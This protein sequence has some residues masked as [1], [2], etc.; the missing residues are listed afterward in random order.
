MQDSILSHITTMKS[1][2][3]E[4]TERS[5]QINSQCSP[6]SSS[7][8]AHLRFPATLGLGDA[9]PALGTGEVTEGRNG[10][11]A[12][13]WTGTGAASTGAGWYCLVAGNESIFFSSMAYTPVSTPSLPQYISICA[14]TIPFRTNAS[15]KPHRT[16]LSPSSSA[17]VVNRRAAHPRICANTAIAERL[18]VDFARA[19]EAICGILEKS[20]MGRVRSWRSGRKVCGTTTKKTVDRATMREARSAPWVFFADRARSPPLP[21]AEGRWYTMSTVTMTFWMARKRFSPSI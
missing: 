17:L 4:N 6:Q 18:P 15:P 11:D 19:F 16:Y 20:E 9:D 13:A 21:E 5:E 12:S 3:N 7:L 14:P 2:P 1:K 10:D 8:R